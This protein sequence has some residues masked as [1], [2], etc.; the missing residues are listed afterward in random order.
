M[1]VDIIQTSLTTAVPSVNADVES[2][3]L[4]PRHIISRGISND[5]SKFYNLGNNASSM[6]ILELEKTQI[7]NNTSIVSIYS[8]DIEKY[9]YNFK[10]LADERIEYKV[11]DFTPNYNFIDEEEVEYELSDEVYKVDFNI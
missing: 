4:I 1:N 9:N 10:L 7:N 5:D 2:R 6:L 11:S 8:T 3:Y